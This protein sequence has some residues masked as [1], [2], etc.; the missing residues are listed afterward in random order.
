MY[1]KFW[2]WH[3]F[4]FVWYWH[5][6]HVSLCFLCASKITQRPALNVSIIQSI[7]CLFYLGSQLQ[8]DV[9]N[10]HPLYTHPKHSKS[11]HIR[12][13]LC[14]TATTTIY[15]YIQ[16]FVHLSHN[17]IGYRSLT[18]TLRP[19]LLLQHNSSS[20]QG[21]TADMSYAYRNCYWLLAIF[22]MSLSWHM[23]VTVQYLQRIIDIASSCNIYRHINICRVFW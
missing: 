8:D 15:N 3:H 7:P 19:K 12:Y 2:Q 9:S 18:H 21:L 13:F 14:F 23:M 11:Y 5:V 10:L 20:W 4:L 16:I 1:L 6:L 22:H 17:F